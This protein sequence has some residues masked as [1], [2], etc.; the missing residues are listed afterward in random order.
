M[1]F[2]VS[3]DMDFQRIF[4]Q[5]NSGENTE[6]VVSKKRPTQ[7]ISLI[8]KCSFCYHP[9]RVSILEEVYGGY[10]MS[11]RKIRKDN[12]EGE[13]NMNVFLYARVSSEEQA[14]KDKSVHD[15]ISY[16]IDESKLHDWNVVGYA[17]DNGHTASDTTRSGL[18]S[19][20]NAIKTEKI[21]LVA[22][23]HND[24]LTRSK[25]DFYGE[26]KR[27]FQKTN[28]NMWFNNLPN[29]DFTSPEGDMVLGNMIN[30]SEYTRKN[31]QRRTIFALK[32][33]Q[34]EGGWVGKAPLGYD[35]G[36]DTGHKLKINKVE[37]MAVRSIYKWYTADEETSIRNIVDRLNS[38]PLFS[39]LKTWNYSIRLILANPVYT[40]VV[41]HD[42]ELVP[43]EHSPLISVELFLKAK[44]KRDRNARCRGKKRMNKSKGKSKK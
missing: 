22:F 8:I 33:K 32:Q 20:I 25:D 16:L 11:N 38:H 17:Y 36:E 28:T 44:N 6:F 14:K 34:K 7:C 37:A 31:T 27:V 1:I 23:Y 3:R 30:L 15:Q 4:G 39:K 9:H 21:D 24:R 5:K 40:G 42:D 13:R 12:S 10:Y 26:L 19:M 29:L 2:L 35:I 18:I 41:I 43:G